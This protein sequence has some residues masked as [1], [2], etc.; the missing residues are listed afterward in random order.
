MAG[1]R[2]WAA[3]RKFLVEAAQGK[4]AKG[5]PLC[6]LLFIPEIFNLEREAEI[7]GRRAAF[8]RPLF[9]TRARGKPLMILIGEVREIATAR[10]GHR[11]VV[12]HL[13]KFPF[14]LDDAIHRRMAAKFAAELSLWAAL[15]DAHLIA[16]ATFGVDPNGVAK[17]DAIALMSVTEN[18]IPFKHGYEAEL[19]AELT[20]RGASFLK[21]L[22]YNLPG[23]RP[24]ASVILREEGA[25]PVALYV[26]PPTAGDDYRAALDALKDES[27]MA[28]WVWNAG[29]EVL[30]P[31]PA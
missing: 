10:F 7:A 14:L 1:K 19:I 13:P 16:I 29:R 15:P 4:T 3:I 5:K 25:A 12:R 28:S 31:L 23:D 6:D 9:E 11:L 21:G 2:N 20:R 17:I 22:R 26:A 24:L 27:G 30:P 8:M 18:W